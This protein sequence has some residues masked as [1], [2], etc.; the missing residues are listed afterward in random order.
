MLAGNTKKIELRN[1]VTGTKENSE[2]LSCLEVLGKRLSLDTFI[3][4][5]FC[6]TRNVN[7]FSI[8]IN[9]ICYVLV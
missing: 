6:S 1:C 2:L 8:Y 5:K 3:F 9:Y 7:K 4:L